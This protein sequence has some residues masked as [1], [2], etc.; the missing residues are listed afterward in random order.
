MFQGKWLVPSK[1]LFSNSNSIS[2][3]AGAISNLTY[4]VDNFSLGLVDEA[5]KSYDDENQY[6]V[7]LVEPNDYL[8]NKF[9]ESDFF[10][11]SLPPYK[12]DTFNITQSS[13]AQATTRSS[14]YFSKEDLLVN[15]EYKD[16]GILCRFYGGL[17]SLLNV[18]CV[19]IV[20]GLHCDK[21]CAIAS[22]LRYNQIVTR[23]RIALYSTTIWSCSAFLSI[24]VISLAP[25]F[26]Y[27]G[28]VCLPVWKKTGELIYTVCLAL[29]LIVA[30]ATLFIL[31]NVKIMLIAR[32]HQHRIF[33][34]I[35]EVMMS[36]Q[37]TV[38][39]QRNPFD[40]PKMKQKSA[41]TVCEQMLGFAMCY[42]PVLLYMVLS[43]FTLYPPSE[44]L[45]VLMVGILLLAPLVNSFLYG[46]KS[47]IIRKLFRN[48]LRKKISKSA[49][50]CEIQARIP[51]AQNSRRPSISSTFGFPVIQKS[52]QRRMSDFLCADIQADTEQREPGRRSSDLSWHPL[53]EGTPT[54]T[55]LRQPLDF[56]LGSDWCSPQD[57][58]GSQYLAVPSYD[59]ARSYN[60]TTPVK[61]QSS[62][63]L[64]S[65]ET[66][67][68]KEIGTEEE[69]LAT[70]AEVSPSLK[71]KSKDEDHQEENTDDPVSFCIS[72]S[73]DELAVPNGSVHGLLA[74]AVPI[75]RRA[76]SAISSVT[77]EDSQ[78]VSSSTP[79]L[80]RAY[81][82]PWPK[83]EP[84]NVNSPYILRTIESLMS[85]GL[86]QSRLLKTGILWRGNSID[87]GLMKKINSTEKELTNGKAME[88][89]EEDFDVI[90]ISNDMN[91]LENDCIEMKESPIMLT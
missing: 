28:G 63:S 73:D 14:E 81:M 48:Y 45:A 13:S 24:I 43:C 52:L 59:A 79:L 30:P 51:S 85:V 21:Y 54:S 70:S 3:P 87:K 64:E 58:R 53:E 62:C 26:M 90:R 84:S 44:L 20:V 34:A 68:M 76:S 61:G 32:Q 40:L 69:I 18:A 1:I 6:D 25:G 36:A 72:A 12:N 35:F 78:T 83:T 27:I 75:Y 88:F 66:I 60:Q 46:V 91:G 55:R 2:L 89:T 67:S 47:T 31:V 7:G 65:G 9:N 33:S 50:K 56:D 71:S 77:S 8:I 15:Y 11:E 82:Q 4:A 74:V 19:W 23:K 42:I 29:V 39:Q 80:C 57:V 16:D 5:Y 37:A 49:M 10:Y 22:P 17:L 38:T 41:W 86:S